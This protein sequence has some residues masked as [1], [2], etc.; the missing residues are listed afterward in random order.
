MDAD[1]DQISGQI[2]EKRFNQRVTTYKTVLCYAVSFFQ[3]QARVKL[4]YKDSK[5]D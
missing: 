4:V 1:C 2:I 3:K 5:K